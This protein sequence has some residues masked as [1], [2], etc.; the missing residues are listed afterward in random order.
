MEKFTNKIELVRHGVTRFATTFLI[1]QRL[2]KQK[3]NLK[4]MFTSNNWMSSKETKE[5]K[6][7]KAINVVLI[8]SFWNDVV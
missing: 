7:K 2:Y 5:L 4:R 1:L 8:P 6:G 3:V